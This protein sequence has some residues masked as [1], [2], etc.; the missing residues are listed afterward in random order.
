MRYALEWKIQF[1][2]S[3]G[4]EIYKKKGKEPAR[5][6][7]GDNDDVD[8]DRYCCKKFSRDNGGSA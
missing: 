1:T 6:E 2:K 8:D 3:Q 4:Q 5:T 7:K